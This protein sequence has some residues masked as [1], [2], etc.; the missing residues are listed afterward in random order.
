M[1]FRTIAAISLCLL[2]KHDGILLNARVLSF[3]GKK[4]KKGKRKKK[5]PAR[6]K[7]IKAFEISEGV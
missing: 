4:K 6:P 7:N 5:Q 1:Q 2:G 3:E